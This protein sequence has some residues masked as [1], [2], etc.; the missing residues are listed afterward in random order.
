MV[1]LLAAL[2]NSAINAKIGYGNWASVGDGCRQQICIQNCGQT[3][4]DRDK[5]LLTAYSISSSPYP[6]IPPP[7]P[8][9]VPFII[10]I[11]YI[12]YVIVHEVHIKEKRKKMSDNTQLRN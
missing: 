11:Y 4:A 8:Y 10:F 6:R 12:Y 3:A 7:T 2:S 1:T 9:D 5:L